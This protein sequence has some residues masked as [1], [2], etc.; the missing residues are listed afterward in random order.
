M[1]NLIVI[2]GCNGSG[3]STFA[4]SFLPDGLISF[5]FDKRF[6]ENYFQ[7]ADSELRE[8]IAKNQTSIEFEN[9]I[10]QSIKT[11]CDFCYET[12]FD[13]HPMHWPNH[14]K[15][16]DY[17]VSLIFFCL[18]NQEIARERVKERTEFKGHFV[19]NKTI[20]YKWKEGY[21]NLNIHFTYFDNLLIV[22]N[23]SHKE[24]YKNIIQ[25]EKDKIEMMTDSIPVY[26][27]HRLPEIYKLLSINH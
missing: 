20:D 15:A 7:L 16:F 17:T 27:K 1:P 4:Q 19:N 21:K 5:D 2:A 6:L 23:S 8:E 24:I 9:A 12:N 10:H 18:E 13:A 26:F 25:V 3:K 11:K 14:F 22:D